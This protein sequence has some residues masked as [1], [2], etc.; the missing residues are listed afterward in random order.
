MVESAVSATL[1]GQLNREYFC[2]VKDT[3]VRSPLAVAIHIEMSQSST[4][5]E[6]VLGILQPCRSKN[7]I[8]GYDFIL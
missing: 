7:H 8:M 3:H 6:A 1:T 2:R 4:L 5:L